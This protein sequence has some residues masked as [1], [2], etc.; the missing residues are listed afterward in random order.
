ML[1]FES[2]VQFMNSHLCSK[3]DRSRF[4]TEVSRQRS[5]RIPQDSRWLTL[6]SSYDAN[7]GE[8]DVQEGRSSWSN[9]VARGS[10]EVCLGVSLTWD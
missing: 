1:L 8:T 2:P 5:P 9:E 7:V 10:L 4:L 3:I 6:V